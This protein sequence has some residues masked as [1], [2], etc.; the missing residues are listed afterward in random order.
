MHDN[1]L[2]NCKSNIANSRN[3]FLFLYEN[4]FLIGFGES[5]GPGPDSVYSFSGKRNSMM[6]EGMVW[7]GSHGEERRGQNTGQSNCGEVLTEI[8][9]GTI[10]SCFKYF[11]Q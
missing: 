11:V 6:R 10:S 1:F 7:L 5:I 2:K 3:F 8:R 9:N 4:L